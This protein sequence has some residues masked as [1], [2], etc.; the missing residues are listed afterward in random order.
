[1]T[2]YETVKI[3]SEYYFIPDN[4]VADFMPAGRQID[5]VKNEAK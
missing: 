1:L 4:P 5:V 3:G 2:F